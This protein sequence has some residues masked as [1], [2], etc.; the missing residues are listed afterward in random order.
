MTMVFESFLAKG[1]AQVSYLLGDDSTGT[2]AVV[3]PRADVD[4]YLDAAQRNSLTITHIFETH[5][6]ADF[7]SGARELAARV[8]SARM[9][10]SREGAADYGF[11]HEPV[12]DGDRF[13]F[14]SVVMTARHTPGHTPEHLSYLVAQTD[15]PNSPW[16]VLTGDSLFVESVGRPDLLGQEQSDELAEQLYHTLRDFYLQLDDRVAVYPGHGAGSACGA[17]IGERPTST[18]GYER[19]FNPFLQLERLDEFKRFVFEGAPPVPHHYP[20]LKQLNAQ[21]P[22]VLHGRPQCPGLT[23]RQFQAVANR[24]TP[25]IDT[26]SMLAFGGGHVPGAINLGGLP[27]L[28]VWAGEMLDPD[29][30]I[31]VVLEEDRSL[32]KILA[33]FLRTGFTQFAGYLVGGMRQWS[34][35]G[36]PLHKTPQVSVHELRQDG[37]KVQLLDVRSPREWNE[38]RIPEATH[39]YVANLREGLPDLDKNRPVVTYCNSGYRASLAA[40]L[41][42]AHGFA[43]VRNVPGSWQAWTNAGF[44]I[45]DAQE[46]VE[47]QG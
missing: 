2:A 8:G 38:G 19:Q 11:E 31:L 36:L 47:A 1:I 14:G 26:R 6:H 12:A 15:R 13:H 17:A 23:P 9:Y 35:Q 28:S 37:R 10:L 34:N 40:S 39:F 4:V 42:Q 5:I 44:P 7:M 33:L 22:P 30:P 43:D 41:L 32:N 3:D 20:R 29:Q 16:G 18:I 45:E 27:E 21:G 46:K 24:G 25:V